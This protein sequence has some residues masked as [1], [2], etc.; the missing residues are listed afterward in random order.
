MSARVF[1]SCGQRPDEEEVARKVAER[2]DGLG[3]RPYVALEAQ[4]IQDVASGVIGELRRSDCYLFIDFRRE[5]LHTT[6]CGDE[7]RGSLFSHQ[8]L[9][10]A[11]ALEF[12]KT[13]FFRESG[14][15]LEGLGAFIM[16]NATVFTDRASLPD[17]VEQAARDRWDPDYS[18]NLVPGKL[19]FPESVIE[20]R[21]LRGRF[22]FLDIHNLRPEAAAAG[23][24]ARLSSMEIA[25]DKK[26][27]S[28]NRSPLKV[29]GQEMT[30]AQTIWPQDHGAFDL[31]CVDYAN[32]SRVYLNNSLDLPRAPVLFEAMGSHILHYEVFAPGFERLTVSVSLRTSG[33]CSEASAEVV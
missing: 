14:V 4:S 19:H 8:E 15:R 24:R 7:Y 28:P 31:L 2:L 33:N 1:S 3:F 20:Y 23:A 32:G 6:P 5:R 18:R 29:T 27:V 16:A 9:G 11:F 12:E 30:F 21:G 25:G 10:I 22:V 17:L 13:L 26:Q